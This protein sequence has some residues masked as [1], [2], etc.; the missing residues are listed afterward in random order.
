[1]EELQEVFEKDHESLDNVPAQ[2]ADPHHHSFL[3]EE[4]LV[5]LQGDHQTR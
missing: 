4:A 5:D 3:Y 2:G 1:L